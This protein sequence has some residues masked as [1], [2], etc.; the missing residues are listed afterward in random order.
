MEQKI[1]QIVS[2]WGLKADKKR[3]FGGMCWL[4]SGNMMCATLASGMVI[5]RVPDESRDKVLALEDVYQAEMNGR[6]MKNWVMTDGTVLDPDTFEKLLEIG[7][8]MAL[9]LPAK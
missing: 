6:V 8:D 7:R 3:M 5:V 1:D 2:N 9:S 4:L